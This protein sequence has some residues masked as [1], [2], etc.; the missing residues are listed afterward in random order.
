MSISVKNRYQAFVLH[1]LL[2]LLLAIG[3]SFLVFYRWYP[4]PYFTADVGWSIFRLI[5]IVHLVLGPVLTFIIFKPGKKGLKFDL[6]AIATLQIAALAYGSAV[7]YQERPAYLT[8]SVDR[9]VLVSEHDIDSSRLKYEELAIANVIN[10]PLLI[11]ARLPK[12]IE[13]FNKLIKEVM[14]GKPDLEF[15]AEFYEPFE[16]N[17]EAV[18]L[19]GADIQKLIK[20]SEEKQ[21]KIEKFL[22]TN[23]ERDCVYFPLVGKKNDVLLALNKND[24]SLMGWI[25]IEPWDIKPAIKTTVH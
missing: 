17:L 3:F 14:Q 18:M 22:K 25:D 19:K 8:F 2:S 23:C 20:T 6:S 9:F 11:Y 16:S 1:F 21:Q 5:I 24:G 4:E 10:R 7:L 12:T 15:R 13:A